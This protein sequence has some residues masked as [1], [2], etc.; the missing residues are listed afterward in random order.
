MNSLIAVVFVL[1]LAA[2]QASVLG[3]GGSAVLVG[4]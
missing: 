3:L 2:A 1:G 4:P